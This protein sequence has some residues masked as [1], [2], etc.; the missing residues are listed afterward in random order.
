MFPEVWPGT[1]KELGFWNSC[2][3]FWLY[4]KELS[5]HGDPQA[6]NTLP[7]S[8]MMEMYPSS[9]QLPAATLAEGPRKRQELVL[10]CPA[11][12]MLGEDGEGRRVMGEEEKL[13]S[14]LE[15][16]LNTPPCF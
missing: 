10:Q 11:G 1:L 12:Q 3:E 2:W 13:S 5:L 16:D 6:W 14:H 7:K 15:E 8:G 9:I 4:K